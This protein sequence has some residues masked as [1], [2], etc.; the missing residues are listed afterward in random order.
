MLKIG[1]KMESSMNMMAPNYLD[2]K[3]IQYLSTGINSYQELARICGVTRNTVYRRI[4]PLKIK[5]S[6]RTY[7]AVR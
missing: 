4:A 1:K 3:I 6:L 7:F 5:E 2:R